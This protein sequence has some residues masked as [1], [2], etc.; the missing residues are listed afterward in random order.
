MYKP[1]GISP[2]A[3]YTAPSRVFGQ[4]AIPRVYTDVHAYG[5][6]YYNCNFNEK[7]FF[8]KKHSK[9]PTF[10]STQADFR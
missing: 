5:M 8:V 3:K 1:K 4:G 6:M 9:I 10:F 7:D 2:E